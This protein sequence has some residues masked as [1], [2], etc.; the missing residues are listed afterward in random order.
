MNRHHERQ[1]SET[2]FGSPAGSDC[3]CKQ[4]EGAGAR[5]RHVQMRVRP[6]YGYDVRGIH[7]FFRDIGMQ[8]QADG[9]RHALSGQI[10]NAPEQFA[11]AVFELFRHHRSVEIEIDSVNGHR[12]GYAREDF[13]GDGFEGFV[14]NEI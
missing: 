6:E 14:A 2:G 1:L 12:V 7:H 13:G 5:F 3:F 8:V 10:A 4:I 9:D 11:F